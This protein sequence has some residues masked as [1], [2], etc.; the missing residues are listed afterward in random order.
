MEIVFKLTAINRST[1]PNEELTVERRS[2]F[3]KSGAEEISFHSRDAK[4]RA[5]L[6]TDARVCAYVCP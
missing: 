4:M 3:S 1:R 6:K 2:T 5:Q